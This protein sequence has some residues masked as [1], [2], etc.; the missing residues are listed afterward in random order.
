MVVMQSKFLQLDSLDSLRDYWEVKDSQGSNLKK[1]DFSTILSLVSQHYL[2]GESSHPGSL[3]LVELARD[4]DIKEV[5]F[6]ICAQLVNEG[7]AVLLPNGAK[8]SEDELIGQQKRLVCLLIDPQFNY[9]SSSGSQQKLFNHILKGPLPNESIS[10]PTLLLRHSSE[11]N[12]EKGGKIY[13]TQLSLDKKHQMIKLWQIAILLFVAGILMYYYVLSI[14]LFFEPGIAEVQNTQNLTTISN[15][16]YVISYSTMAMGLAFLFISVCISKFVS[17]TKAGLITSLGLILLFLFMIFPHYVLI[18]SFTSNS[19][20]PGQAGFKLVPSSLLWPFAYYLSQVLVFPSWWGTW[21]GQI[22]L[23]SAIILS[24]SFGIYIFLNLRENF[25]VSIL[26]M[27]LVAL[28][29]VFS[30]LTNVYS[31]LVRLTFSTPPNQGALL[32]VNIMSWIVNITNLV[33]PVACL[34]A[35][36]PSVKT[37]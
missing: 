16:L 32:V 15:Y 7:Y 9:S 35:L 2:E 12:L 18:L 19:T 23:N 31:P 10:F 28:N 21:E 6:E 8:N 5:A 24:I 17:L 29:V 22:F 3:Y 36:L 34:F 11:T 13:A 1:T 20:F 27:T 37:T 14:F 26:F 33:V 25:K 30:S 4:V